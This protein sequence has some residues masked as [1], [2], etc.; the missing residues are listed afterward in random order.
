MGAG[1]APKEGSLWESYLRYSDEQ[2]FEDL[3]LVKDFKA[4]TLDIL[5]SLGWSVCSKRDSKGNFLEGISYGAL[6]SEE[7]L[8]R[9]NPLIESLGSVDPFKGYIEGESDSYGFAEI[10]KFAKH[11]SISDRDFKVSYGNEDIS[12]QKIL[13]PSESYQPIY[14]GSPVSNAPVHDKLPATKLDQHYLNK[15]QRIYKDLTSSTVPNAR[16]GQTMRLGPPRGW[17]QPMP[18]Q[19]KGSPTDWMRAQNKPN[20]YPRPFRNVNEMRR[21]ED[22]PEFPGYQDM[23]RTYSSHEPVKNRKSSE[24]PNIIN[25]SN[26]LDPI[27]NYATNNAEDFGQVN[28]RLFGSPENRPYQDKSKDINEDEVSGDNHD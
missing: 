15:D 19:G 14:N 17:R 11:E 20:R 4:K 9:S 26:L 23:P 6:E 25:K 8:I 10:V 24:T 7:Y 16:V 27:Q 5:G 13:N 22:T 3:V 1:K 18:M 28:S 12:Q 2:E 21:Y